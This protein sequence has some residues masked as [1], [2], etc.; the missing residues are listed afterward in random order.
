M[1]ASLRQQGVQC[2]EVVCRDDSEARVRW[3]LD[4]LIE[5]P[6]DVF[7]P[8]LVVPAL[9]AG[10]FV[11]AAGIS[12]V[13]ILHSDDDFY[14]GVR[15]VFVGGR[16]Q[17]A[18][19]DLVC[20]SRELE[21]QSL[22]SSH[23]R[24]RIHRIPYGVPKPPGVANRVDGRLRVAYVGR[25]AEE[26][27]RI[28]EVTRAFCRMTKEI[29]GT[30]AAIFGEGPDRSNIERILS[31]EGRGQPVTLVGRVA[32]E[33]IQRRLCEFDVI[34]L[35]SDYEGLPIAI[36][37][38][39]ACGVVPVCLKMRS[40]IPELVEDGVTG[41]VIADRDEKFIAAIRQLKTDPHLWQR[42]SDAARIRVQSENSEAV[43]AAQWASLLH[44]L[45]DRFIP[46]PLLRKPLRYDFPPVHP[47]LAAEDRRSK[48]QGTIENIFLSAKAAARKMRELLKTDGTSLK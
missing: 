33:Q 22:E 9:L 12:T 43:C 39:M 29:P 17:D 44:E 35:M 48:V 47:A 16:R 3:I 32:V 5:K 6:P 45:A 18:L 26:Q 4:R 13:G 2:A 15:E 37:E 7:V 27:K 38:A 25:L 46:G 30:E 20:V 31:S 40:G 11:R 41:L 28:S 10:Q 14:R 34:V 23:P 36:L 42:L 8:N 1:L 21:K 19:T 24:T